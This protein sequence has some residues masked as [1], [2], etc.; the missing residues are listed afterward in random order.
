MYKHRVP[1]RL[2]KKQADIKA[3]ALREKLNQQRSQN[4][5]ELQKKRT[6]PLLLKRTG[7]S[8][9]ASP[10]FA[11]NALGETTGPLSRLSE[12]TTPAQHPINSRMKLYETCKEMSMPNFPRNGKYLG[13]PNEII[14]SLNKHG[15]FERKVKIPSS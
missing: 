5:L 6:M 14:L 8:S 1:E 2:L 15:E 7:L 4:Q 11:S 12:E 10:K 3:V 9:I 13:P